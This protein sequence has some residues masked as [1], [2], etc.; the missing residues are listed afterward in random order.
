VHTFKPNLA[1][2]AAQDSATMTAL[3]AMLQSASGQKIWWCLWHEPENDTIGVTNSTNSFTLSDYLA[4]WRVFADTMHSYN[5]PGWKACWVMMSYTWKQSFLTANPSY[6][7]DSWYPGDSYVDVIGIDDYNEGSLH[8]SPGDGTYQRWDSP[9]YGWGD[10]NFNESL[11]PNGGG[12][13][14]PKLLPWIA[15]RGKDYAICEFG[16]IRNLSSA[17]GRSKSDPNTGPYTLNWWTSTYGGSNS[18]ADWI[19]DYTKYHMVTAPALF[20]TNC[21]ALM[22]FDCN[23]R[24]WAGDNTESWELFHTPGDVDYTAWGDMLSMY[25]V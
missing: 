15:A 20:G 13:Y 7:P 10:P 18:K 23:G 17:M 6:T 9:G 4:A 19:K 2:L 25:G 1:L 12:Y 24:K 16:T 5:E 8:N 11:G 21:I 14:S 22:Y 3:N